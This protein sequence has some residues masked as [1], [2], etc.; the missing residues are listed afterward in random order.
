MKKLDQKWV[1]FFVAILFLKL[2]LSYL[3]PMSADEAYY[4]VWSQKPQLSY[5][6][7]PPFVSWLFMIANLF[8][9]PGTLVR[10]PAVILGQITLLIAILIFQNKAK[11][12][13]GL[14]PLTLLILIPLFNIGSFILTP[15]LPVIF[16][17]ILSV[18]LWEQYEKNL[19]LKTSLYFGLSLGLGFSSKYHIVLFLPGF[20]LYLFFNKKFK[21]LINRNIILIT[22]AGL[23]GC[24][25][26][27]VWNLQNDFAS[28]TFQ[29]A[30]GL[31]KSTKQINYA[32][33]YIV[34][35]FFILSPILIHFFYKHWNKIKSE[36]LFWS[37]IFPV[38]FFFIT[39]F[40][41]GVEGN[42]PTVGYLGLYL[43]YAIYN[44]TIKPLAIYF[45]SISLV[46]GF[47]MTFNIG[48]AGD[49]LKELNI[50][51]KI[52]PEIKQYQPLYASKY[53]IA[54]QL[55]FE[56]QQPVYKLNQMSRTD[57]FDYMPESK[58]NEN[59]FYLL[60]N[61]KDHLPNWINQQNYQVEDFKVLDHD[62]VLQR[63]YK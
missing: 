46:I 32:I 16:F 8:H 12:K 31:E 56:L 52:A 39:S 21:F 10:I 1:I 19:D 29:L 43:L 36:L 34:S 41:T 42:W 4:W 61:T 6:D 59:Q 7:H 44:E 33:P 37:G 2:I 20:F 57:F 60:K 51:Q 18:Y 53:Q 15:D 22:I 50:I 28:F 54:S 38:V 17:W 30:H 26:V 27:I 5:Y 35:Q 55:W 49:K 3:L 11:Q 47:A 40:R 23:V 45:I 9:L 62:L 25:P 24:L 48:N 14:L 63:I 13:S 58:P